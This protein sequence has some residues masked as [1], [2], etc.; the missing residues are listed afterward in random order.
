[1]TNRK[2]NLLKKWVLPLA[3]IAS[4]IVLLLYLLG[5]IG[6]EKTGP[7]T[8]PVRAEQ[9]P[10]GLKSA[11]VEKLRVKEMIAWPATVHS[12]T[13]AEIAPKLTARVLEIRVD[14]G[15]P[16]R[17]G[18][19]IARLDQKSIAAQERK[20]AAALAAAKAMVQRA[21]A[22]ERRTRDLFRQEAATRETFDS[23][24]AR[25][26]SARAK[27]AEAANALAAV[28]A[29][30]AETVLKA[31]FDGVV[32][33]RHAEPGDMGLPGKP[34]VTIQD[35][36]GLRVESYIPVR[37]ARRLSVGDNATVRI[38]ALGRS[39][40]ARIDAI[41]PQA[42]PQTHTVLIKAALPR[43]SGLQ[44]GLFGWL[45]QACGERGVLLIP[46]ASIERIGQIESVKVVVDG[47][48]RLRHVRTGKAY[49]DSVEVLSGLRAGESVLV[50]ETPNE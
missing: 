13:V 32:V 1:M 7:G 5:L 39:L 33:K 15:D 22:D 47:T 19:V 50:N 11:R 28:R 2:K 26:K 34:I 31:P 4:L 41:I 43:A 18:E 24:T 27:V 9:P 25:A 14:A 42:D 49:D 29:N 6:A 35:P 46:A 20:A 10:A 44:P 23:V 3:S 8:T 12:R 30:R 48:I 17:K 36:A 40:Q 38:D 45:E 37:C 16:I 21:L